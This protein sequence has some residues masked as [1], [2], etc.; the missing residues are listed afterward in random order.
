M[1]DL[2]EIW[3]FRYV[4]TCWGGFTFYAT[5]ECYLDLASKNSFRHTRPIFFDFLYNLY[6]FDWGNQ[7]LL[8]WRIGFGKYRAKYPKNF[9]CQRG[10]NFLLKNYFCHFRV[11]DMNWTVFK[12]MLILAWWV[13][14]TC[15]SQHFFLNTRNP[16]FLVILKYM[17]LLCCL[18]YQNKIF[19]S[20]DRK[21]ITISWNIIWH[22]I[23]VTITDTKIHCIISYIILKRWLDEQ[24][25]EQLLFEKNQVLVTW[26]RLC[27]VVPFQNLFLE[28]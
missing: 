14:V 24:Q 20:Q 1:S 22:F 18:S 21:K 28:I 12:S 9:I 3:N 16:P 7:I 27:G 8:F 2:F 10:E 6:L 13:Y 25:N 26:E 23:C 17:S 19:W 11:R 4:F 15:I 5:H